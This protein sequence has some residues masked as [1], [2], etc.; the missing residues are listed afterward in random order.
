MNYLEETRGFDLEMAD[1]YGV[2]MQALKRGGEAVAIAYRRNG[3]VYGHKIRPL[4]PGEGSRFFFHPRDQVRD[5]WNVD[6]LSDT[7]LLD[8]PIII[9]EGEL[10]ALSC[11]AAGFPR[12]VSIPDGWTKNFTGDDGPKSKPILANADRLKRSPFVIIAGDG[13]ETGGSFVHAVRNMLDGHPCKFVE[14]PQGCKDANDV[15]RKHGL[16]ELARMLNAARWLEPEGGMI[17]G[18]ADLPPEAPMQIFRTGHPDFDRVILFHA[19]FPTIVTG[20]P[21]SGKSTFTVCALHQV[22]QNTGIR[23]GVGMFETPASVLRDHLCRLN[24]GQPW[25][26]TGSADRD[27]LVAKLDRH[28]RIIHKI[29]TDRR[30]HDMGW[31]R[32]MMHAAAVRD[33]CKIVMLDPWNEIEHMPEKGENMTDYLNVALAR[34]RQWAERF[35]CAACIVAHPTKMQ[36]EAGAKPRAPLGYDIS[37]SAAWF[38]KAAIGVTVHQVEGEDRHVLVINWKSKF[39]QQ[40]GIQKG[41]QRF[42]FDTWA[43]NYRGRMFQ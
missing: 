40:Y 1:R 15:L 21:S 6:V 7:T 29:D 17:T 24:T 43:M 9:T 35:D 37:A 33:G 11:V 32:D 10:D 39:Q 25:D 26:V 13:D 27:R 4:D 19:G 2:T 36:A 38:N 20:I 30:S 16:G 31:I 34:I 18:F 8:Q 23:V 28:W 42:D 5:L 3:E 22:V 12:S 41:N 14:Y